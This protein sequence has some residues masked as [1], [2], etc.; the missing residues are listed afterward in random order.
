MEITVNI[1]A[2]IQTL[3]GF[4]REDCTKNNR[5]KDENRYSTQTEAIE[6]LSGK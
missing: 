2:V 5:Q 6:I 4:V 3:A 1:V